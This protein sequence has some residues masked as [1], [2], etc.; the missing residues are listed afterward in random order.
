MERE[1]MIE[2]FVKF[3]REYTEE[4]EPLYLG[5]IKDLLTV[6]PKRSVTINWM[7]LNSYDPELANEVLEH[8]EEGIGAA[9]DAIQIVLREDFLREDLPRIHARFYNLPETLLVK[10]I[11]AEHINKLVQVEGV[12]TRVTEIKPFV[13]R[14]VFVC[15]DCG[16]EMVVTQRP[17]EGF[18]VVKKCEVCGSKNVALDV[19]K[20]SFVNFQMF[21]IQDRPETLKG[22]QMPRFIDGI[23][24][25]DIVDTA[26]PGDRVLVTGILRV[27][28]ERREKTPVFRKVLE[29]NHIEPVSKEIEELEITPE[30]EQ[31]I[32]ELAK[33]KDIVEAIVDSIAPAIYGYREVKKGIALALFGGVPRTLPDGTRLRG[34]IHVLLVGDPGVAKSQILRYVS[35]LAPRAIYTS[36]KSSSAAGLTAAAVRDEFTGGWVLEAGALVLADGGYALIDELDKMSDRDRS[37]IH[38]ALEQQ[39]YHHDFEILLADGRKVK[40]GELV[41]SLI[42]KNR[43]R[44]IVGKD[45][46]ILPVDDIYVLAYD[47]KNKRIVKVKADRV[48]RHKAPEHFIG[49]KFSNGRE[50]V[51]TPEHPIMIWENGEIKEKPAEEV[52]EGEMVL[53]VRRYEHLDSKDV[54]ERKAKLIALLLSKLSSSNGQYFEIKLHNKGL[55]SVLDEIGVRYEL[56]DDRAILPVNELIKFGIPIDLRRVPPEIMCGSREV[57]LTFLKILLVADG[58][59]SGGMAKLDL[60]SRELAED[61]QDLL[62]SLGISSEISGNVLVIF[63]AEVIL[64]GEETS[65]DKGGENARGIRV[66]EV[67]KIPNKDWKWV[68]DVT[69]EPY[70]LFVSHGLVLHNTISISKAGITATLNART[71]VIAAANPKHGRFNRMKPLFEQID[72]PPTLLSRFDLIFVL[73]DEPDEKLDSE[74]ARHILRVRRGESE[75]V[76]PKISHELLRK[77]IAYAKKNVHPVI[78]EEAMEEIEKYYVRMRRSAKKG[79]ENEGIRPIPITARQLEALIRLSEAHARMRLS[80]IVTREDA[81]EA[82]KLMEY[83][84]RQI[85][86]DETGQIDVTI[87]EV[88]QSARKL[89]KVERILDI[90]EKLQKT[91]EKGAHIDDILEEAKKFGIEKQEAREIIEKLLQQGQIYM[92][93]TG[94]YK[95][96]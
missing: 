32:R 80:P 65:E 58:S 81:R 9:E 30:D 24:L 92:P 39:S 41:D 82:I 18:T 14:A 79:S 83:T 75:V 53:G 5:K 46:E 19:D 74:I 33:R 95:L 16:N 43:D 50:I 86:T 52:K 68:Y 60:I 2:R 48:S 6:T 35:N 56:A 78:S 89:S 87:L 63:D 38:E 59:I 29:V 25:D 67:E 37:V 45:T 47:L 11:G 12:I 94:Y 61:V 70:H 23:L 21:R 7:H 42:E 69:V 90:I 57:K 15:K 64:K 13:S 44:V 88:G 34:D 27:V 76:T 51:V 66:V 77:Y 85:A 1:E 96:L 10:D 73:V 49:L 26:M 3:F 28:Q 31:K 4:E 55:K 72:L 71:T 40:I 17:Y 91:S 22:G 54:D 84:L 93:E 8:P 20:S 62:L 36:G